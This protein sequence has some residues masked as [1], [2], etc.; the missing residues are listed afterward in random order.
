MANKKV[1]VSVVNTITPALVTAN[2]NSQNPNVITPQQIA[3]QTKNM[4][5]A[6]EKSPQ[7][8]RG[9]N[10]IGAAIT[11]ATPAPG[12]IALG[13]TPQG[14]KF[15]ESKYD[16]NLNIRGVLGIDEVRGQRQTNA[17]KWANGIVKWAGK[18]ATVVAGGTIGTLY[19][20]GSM[21]TEGKGSAFYNNSFA[22]LLDD[23]NE[24]MDGALPHYYTE[25][26][27]TEQSLWK[28]MATANFFSDQMLNGLSFISGAILTE[29]ATAGLGTFM[30]GNT[31]SRSARMLKRLNNQKQMTSLAK[32]Y[33]KIGNRGAWMDAGKL[34]RQTVTGA[35]YEAGVE[36]RHHYDRIYE[37]LV[38]DWEE[39][40]PGQV[41]SDEE[42]AKFSD[43]ATNQ[44][45]GVFL[46][47]L[48][49]VGGSNALML[50]KLYGPG[51]ALRSKFSK[52]M[53]KVFPGYGRGVVQNEAGEY[54]ARYTRPLGK[55]GEKLGMGPRAGKILGRG[56]RALV[57]PLYEG[58]VEE[59]GQSTLSEIGYD[60]A[61]LKYSSE[62]KKAKADLISSIGYGFQQTYGTTEGQTEIA[63]GALLGLIGAKGAYTSR[64]QTEQ[65]QELLAKANNKYPDLAT[66]IKE[67]S[68]FM[69]KDHVLQR[70]MDQHLMDGNTAAYK[71]LENDSFFSYVKARHD[72]GYFEDIIDDAKAVKEMTNE[73]F[74]ETFNY[75]EGDFKDDA[76]ITARKNKVA[77]DAIT[78]A[79]KIRESLNTADQALSSRMDDPIDRLTDENYS[80][81]REQIAHELTVADN[82][83]ERMESLKNSIAEMTNGTVFPQFID[84][85]QTGSAV[86]FSTTNQKGTAV[87]NSTPFINMQEGTMGLQLQALQTRL[88]EN[89]NLREDDP[90]KLS[91]QDVAA[92][93]RQMASIQ[94]VIATAGPS[95]NLADIS[96]EELLFLEDAM[97]QL[98]SLAEKDPA[99]YLKVRDEIIDMLQ[100]MR[101]LRARRQTAFERYNALFTK[102][103]QR[104]HFQRLERYADQIEKKDAVEDMRGR[105][106]PEEIIQL[107]ERYGTNADLIFSPTN[108]KSGLVYDE[109]GLPQN[110][111]GN[112]LIV[113]F[114]ENNNLYNVKTG[115]PID[116]TELDGMFFRTA[117]TDKQKK[118][119]EALEAIERLK[120]DKVK[121][122]TKVQQDIEDITTEVFELMLE[123]E[124][125]GYEQLDIRKDKKGRT[126]GVIKGRKGRVSINTIRDVHEKAVQQINTGERLILE[127]QEQAA[128]LVDSLEFLSTLAETHYNPRTGEFDISLDNRYGAEMTNRISAMNEL[129]I[130]DLVEDPTNYQEAR[131]WAELMRGDVNEFVNLIEPN[132]QLLQQKIQELVDYKDVLEGMLLENL[133]KRRLSTNRYEAAR[134]FDDMLADALIAVDEFL[135]EN[136]GQDDPQVNA[137][138]RLRETLAEF[139]NYRTYRNFVD[140]NPAFFTELGDFLND[141]EVAQKNIDDNKFL[142]AELKL[143]KEE[144][145]QLSGLVDQ[146]EE[147][148]RQI[149]D[150][151]LADAIIE[152]TK[153]EEA[154][155]DIMNKL[156]QMEELL[157]QTTE[158]V[159]SNED[160]ANND[161][162]TSLQGVSS[163]LASN[164]DDMGENSVG[165]TMYKPSWDVGFDKTAGNMKVSQ[166]I[167]N[168]LKDR[169]PESLTEEE[170][171]KLKIATHEMR[172]FDY[173]AG[174][175]P[176]SKKVKGRVVMLAVKKGQQIEGIE[177]EELDG[178]FVDVN[179]SV[180][181]EDD[182][183]FT[184]LDNNGYEVVKGYET[185]EAAEQDAKVASA[186]IKFVVA[187]ENS[188]RPVR[189]EKYDKQLI[190]SSMMTP[191]RFKPFEGDRAERFSNLA[192]ISDTDIA[193]LQKL[194]IEERRAILDNEGVTK[195][196]YDITGTSAGVPFLEGT[197]NNR[198]SHNVRGRVFL[199]GVKQDTIAGANIEI[200]TKPV[201]NLPGGG[202]M[203]TR[204]GNAFIRYG[205]TLY[206]VRYRT[207]E[208][209]EV[210]QVVNLLRL[211]ETTIQ[212]LRQVDP[213]LT[214]YQALQQAERVLEDQGVTSKISELIDNLIYNG[215]L[216]EDQAQFGAQFQFFFDK[217]RK[218]YAFGEDGFI[219]VEQ[220]RTQDPT[221][222][223]SFRTFLSS[224][225]HQVNKQ[226]LNGSKDLSKR[227]AHEKVVLNDDLSVNLEDSKIGENSYN[228]YEE[229]LLDGD[230][231]VLGTAVQPKSAQGTLGQ[232]QV[233]FKYM[234]VQQKASKGKAKKSN[235]TSSETNDT[236]TDLQT[237]QVNY[238]KS[239]IDKINAGDNFYHDEQMMNVKPTKANILSLFYDDMSK[240]AEESAKYK[241]TDEIVEKLLKPK[242]EAYKKDRYQDP[243]AAFINGKARKAPIGSTPATETKARQAQQKSAQ[244]VD[245]YSSDFSSMMSAVMDLESDA[246][247]LSDDI[248]KD[249]PFDDL[250]LDDID[251]DEGANMLLNTM[252]TERL[253]PEQINEQETILKEMF[254]N[255]NVKRVT[256]YIRTK[257]GKAQ[258]RLERFGTI[259]LSTLAESGALYH[260]AWHNTSLYLLG[261]KDL[262]D[263]YGE[264]RNNK[265][266]GVTYKGETKNFSEFTDKEADEYLAEEFRKYVLTNGKHKIG[267]T[268]VKTFFDF[269]RDILDMLN[270]F[271]DNFA[272]TK[273]IFNDIRKGR[274]AEITP[275]FEMDGKETV[276]MAVFSGDTQLDNDMGMTMH[277]YWMNEMFFN[278]D[279]PITIAELENMG[280]INFDL[281]YTTR[282]KEG[283]KKALKAMALDYQKMIAA[284]KKKGFPQEQIKV[285]EQRLDTLIKN[286]Q[287][288]VSVHRAYLRTLS[289]GL[290][291]TTENLAEEEYARL[292]GSNMYEAMEHDAK[293][294]ASNAIKL[295]VSSTP[296]DLNTTF[297]TGAVHY[298]EKMNYLHTLL[299]GSLS[300][301]DQIRMLK[302]VALEQPWVQDLI[303]K[304]E[305]DVSDDMSYEDLKL[306][307]MFKQQF[308]KA[309]NDFALMLTDSQ[310]N[311]YSIDPN[312]QKVHD[313]IMNMFTANLHS[314]KGL[315]TTKDG[316]FVFDITHPIKLE[317]IKLPK[318][319][320]QINNQRLIDGN[321]V[322]G[323]LDSLGITF[324]NPDAVA[325]E[326]NMD[327]L[328]DTAY[329]VVQDIVQ[330]T[331]GGELIGANVFDRNNIDARS[332]LSDL[333][334]LE[335]ST[336]NTPIDLSHLNFAGKMV[337]G[338]TLNTFLNIAS[339][340]AIMPYHG[341]NNTYSRNSRW[342][343][344]M[345]LGEK[346]GITVLEG[347]TN[348]TTSA[349]GSRTSSLS[350]ADQR[351]V[352]LNN[353]LNGVAPLLRAADQRV[354]YGFAIPDGKDYVENNTSI[355]D[356]KPVLLGYVADEI[357][358]AAEFN[359]K[360]KG[361][362]FRDYKEKAGG[363]RIFESILQPL[364]DSNTAFKTQLSVALK[365]SAQAQQEFLD[366]NKEKIFNA[367]REHLKQESAKNLRMMQQF[368]I[369]E[370]GNKDFKLHGIDNQTANRLLKRRPEDANKEYTYGE[371]QKLSDIFTMHYFVNNIEQFKVFLGDPAF[372]KSLFKRT[373]GAAGTK[374]VAGNDAIVNGWMQQPENGR[375]DGREI[376]GT[377]TINI[378]EDPVT[379]SAFADEYA[380]AN[381]N[382]A[383]A[384]RDAYNNIDEA[385]AMVYS[386]I[387]STYRELL[388]RVG[389]WSDL[390]EEYYQ[391]SKAGELLT[392]EEL[393]AFPVIKPQYFGPQI[394]S[395]GQFAPLMLK[396]ALAPIFPQMLE[397]N[398]QPTLLKKMYDDMLDTK[399][400]MLGFPSAAKLGSRVNKRKTKA[401]PMFKN[402]VITDI[403]P[404]NTSV[405]DYNFFGIQVDIS[406][407]VKNKTTVGTQQR[408]LVMVDSYEAGIP[409][410]FQPSSTQA[411]RQEAWNKLSPEGKLKKSKRHRQIVKYNNLINAF[412]KNQLQ[413]VLDTLGLEKEGDKY[414]LKNGDFGGF[415]NQLISEMRKRELPQNVIDGVEY[416]L[417]TNDPVLFDVLLN[418]NRIENLLFALVRNR[419]VSHKFKGDM[420]VQM[421][422]TGMQIQARYQDPNDGKLRSAGLDNL[423]AYRKGPN[424]TLSMEVYMPHYLKEYLG[425]NLTIKQDGIYDDQNNK[426]A[427]REMLE[428]IGFRIPTDGLHSIDALIVKGF[429]PAEYGSTIMI[430]PEL[431]VKAGGDFDI[432]KLTLYL[433][434]YKKVGNEIVKRNLINA[435][436][437]TD[438]G[439]KQ[440][441][442]DRYGSTLNFAEQL[443]RD[444]AE[445][446]RDSSVEVDAAV[447]KLMEA[448]FGD[449]MLDFTE[450]ELDVLEE[451]FKEIQKIEDPALRAKEA[452][453]QYNK[454]RERVAKVPSFEEFAEQYRDVDPLVLEHPGALQ[455][456][457]MG[458]QRELILSPDNFGPLV[459]PIS[460]NRIREEALVIRSLKGEPANENDVD[461]ATMISFSHVSKVAEDFWSAAVGVG[462]AA[463]H[464]THNVKSQL[465]DV[466]INP[467]AT[468][469]VMDVADPKT[470]SEMPVT[471]N[472]EGYTEG[473]SISIGLIEDLD[474]NRVS[475]TLS[476][477]VN[478]F[479]D[480]ANDP[481]IFSLNMN[482]DTA[483]A[484]FALLRAGLPLETV[485]RFLNQ[486]VI[487]D[488]IREKQIAN[489]RI[490]KSKLGRKSEYASDIVARVSDKYRRDLPKGKELPTNTKFTRDLLTN[491]IGKSTKEM[492][493]EE[494]NMQIQ[495]LQDFLR[496]DELGNKLGRLLDATAADTT[497]PKNRYE[498]KIM[499]SLNSDIL[500]SDIFL[501]TDRLFSDTFMGGFAEVAT[502]T[503]Y[504]FDEFFINDS[505]IDSIHDVFINPELRVSI[506][507]RVRAMREAESDF[508]T[509]QMQTAVFDNQA[510]SDRIKTL[511]FGNNSLPSR[512]ETLR[513]QGSNN[514]LVNALTPLLSVERS[515]E[516]ATADNMKVVTASLD[517]YTQDML[518]DAF[519]ALPTTTQQDLIEFAIL[520]SGLSNSPISFINLLPS[521]RV[522]KMA[523][524]AIEKYS[525]GG[526]KSAEFFD[527]F[528]QNNWDK[529]YVVPTV[530]SSKVPADSLDAQY[531]FVRVREDA[532]GEQEA[533]R[534]RKEGKRVPTEY[535][536]LKRTGTKKIGDRS[537]AKYAEMPKYGNGMG[538]KEYYDDTR[539]SVIETNLVGL[540]KKQAREERRYKDIPS[541]VKLPDLALKNIRN[542]V[543][544]T[545]ALP[546]GTKLQSGNYTLPDGTRVN[547]TKRTEGIG[548]DAT[549]ITDKS[550]FAREL[551]FKNYDSLLTNIKQSNIPSGFFDLK[552]RIHIFDISNVEVPMESLES[553]RDADDVTVAFSGPS[554]KAL[555]GDGIKGPLY[556]AVGRA[557]EARID[558]LIG[559]GKRNFVVGVNEG[560]DYLTL[561]TLLKAQK[562]YGNKNTSIKIK[563][564]LPYPGFETAFKDPAEKLMMTKMLSKYGDLNKNGNSVEYVVK[565]VP[566]TTEAKSKVV[567][568]R[569]AKLTDMAGTVVTVGSN[570][571]SRNANNKGRTVDTID[572]KEMKEMVAAE[573]K[574]KKQS[575]KC[576]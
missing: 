335:A 128:A 213:T 292:Q 180:K 183:T 274:F 207:L 259:T 145:D 119:Q 435:S 424:K 539:P 392:N 20:I 555:D 14:Q 549:S 482:R 300:Y 49:L 156:L 314:K 13:D 282:A 508:I 306:R 344:M 438:A 71:D 496:Y 153:F 77:N 472:F 443:D 70:L 223:S 532:V 101:H 230:I 502:E 100:D 538:L 144:L 185:Q 22:E 422:E 151:S 420:K 490:L 295:L 316:R 79:N 43:I 545:I 75:K 302:R 38:Q 233:A 385:D 332:R 172:F 51:A 509:M 565:N 369:A 108:E 159:D 111:Q 557:I 221:A 26:E 530:R 493:N 69:D 527:K 328:I 465:A 62:S 566:K 507:D 571:V 50:G 289:P 178:L 560:T 280:D 138:R 229:F 543:K 519:E 528:F 24:A 393:A 459:N 30:L 407:V 383:E 45:N 506:Q 409:V 421:P 431:V 93:K 222:M 323:V 129:G 309:K 109:K 42:R 347:M 476:S 104:K 95:A 181:K 271:S 28:K 439:L 562:D 501:N 209:E 157:N 248:K 315:V 458:I 523:H 413:S 517:K 394:T 454:F 198:P 456:E 447:D 504:M 520:Q 142:R 34:V 553:M 558:E 56:S 489:S 125:K 137:I 327:T 384:V 410:D 334:E 202:T 319:L 133:A 552:N 361:K 37:A 97:E 475:K 267:S 264:V 408:P 246:Q 495:A 492:T 81:L 61:M 364:A 60:Y 339:S 85:E 469:E 21:I 3:T 65:V 94:M 291:V 276:N 362:E 287:G 498:S 112:E 168:S 548:V 390:Q 164:Q 382:N 503:S 372:Y 122:L 308:A 567:A 342:K 58:F 572:L 206:P 41:L 277:R 428:I 184:I 299:A 457:I 573:N 356:L 484:G 12:V 561:K 281:A 115:D 340:G 270:P 136:E 163:D 318:S 464:V 149:Q 220:L 83:E 211:R 226:N 377:D 272:R 36:A 514:L 89:D 260:E 86:G 462:I 170:K 141:I 497:A 479:I 33:G 499:E 485:S 74:M 500:N 130:L 152:H 73:E 427:G 551:G 351:A 118:A 186:P 391:K 160:T 333:L 90:D 150:T 436:T 445:I 425:K 474:G 31:A 563:A 290:A 279:A 25:A 15:G 442:D 536:L 368:K 426:I 173:T 91:D 46:G 269:M 273:E 262:D 556:K 525:T 227:K 5:E 252:E 131:E 215:K 341:A 311:L 313:G 114:D 412:T 35:G 176:Y 453:A 349:T 550:G 88:E 243:F 483:N 92:I 64:V 47:N 199:P 537:F 284:A 374:K 576:N 296:G 380:A 165:P 162:L 2:P 66:A 105:M 305:K 188:L 40:N 134:T 27:R 147:Q 293:D 201:I 154:Y 433:P 55:L 171:V 440:Y 99:T 244:P 123:I 411:Q 139:P 487:L 210:D 346:F 336:S 98:D 132:T 468:L 237:K 512:I 570:S 239:L 283:Y 559:Q 529:E 378:K 116:L 80:E 113:R 401:D 511:M 381:P 63:M 6:Q 121:E 449:N 430:P 197:T 278:D 403:N 17:D 158:D 320:R 187:Y 174:Y 574:L 540:S 432:D 375:I 455:N 120:K 135:A 249:N 312:K 148:K 510:M 478:G 526:Q 196:T 266:K 245:E 44:S 387:G 155:Y 166:Q 78:R 68:K 52:S 535:K 360:G 480:V 177:Q 167:Y 405:I 140:Q 182:G 96:R 450:G 67:M 331:E 416:L 102:E 261:K 200:A 59:G 8:L 452:V 224:K 324:T 386:P 126:Y 400:G 161:A 354:E 486:P 337:H 513:S 481:Y 388:V 343:D 307:T 541:N 169:D 467:N 365:G 7:E 325:V 127:L 446:D 195:I 235:I 190:T 522:A 417:N 143:T 297:L 396:F 418:K 39:N 505:V 9:L 568:A 250:D 288:A 18:T 569:N 466:R 232:P 241:T 575:E 491:M 448:I 205:G 242:L 434:A 515:G 441:Y 48:A 204:P 10:Q 301:E 217:K 218:G 294:M 444:L 254:P 255:V 415:A 240:M 423:Q 11:T 258:A 414:K 225:T 53:Q 547:L 461:Y 265:G 257:D 175:I 203:N 379:A 402:G 470:K 268:K 518:L 542:S 236:W 359:R 216:T 494:K 1:P 193:Y 355:E 463:R 546:A 219:S 329:Y 247:K 76:E 389:D 419:A 521:P 406:P 234:K 19:G 348:Q 72:A 397:R 189:L 84:G 251:L 516:L 398:G 544:R 395:D 304:L 106:M 399:T 363:L 238:I 524:Q 146:F 404:D 275:R 117:V 231:P 103:G 366:T 253:S 82:V 531:P 317:G 194:N 298:T 263:V 208:S 345:S 87:I 322:M 533:K 54:L 286:F 370:L 29:M 367:I 564:V 192:G 212:D 488:Y 429:L 350:P 473:E 353:T 357:A 534:L 471:L 352:T 23:A 179:Y 358:V 4:T 373:K 321:T 338:I 110:L 32:Q 326:E 460:I 451:R 285:L 554:L 228:S 57:S 107:A 214:R 371:L 191:T 303:T 256:D 16:T 376:D 330:K 477:T 124:E 437:G 310:G